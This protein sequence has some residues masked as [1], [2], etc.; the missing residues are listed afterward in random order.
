MGLLSFFKKKSVNTNIFSTLLGLIA[1]K[2]NV[3]DY[4]NA[5]V[6][7]VYACIN[8]KATDISSIELWME[9]KKGDKWEKLSRHDAIDLLNDVNDYYTSS[10]LMFGT[11]AWLE[12]DGNSYWYVVRNGRGI[13]V[14][15]WPLESS[16][17]SIVRGGTKLIKGYVYHLDNG[18]DVPFDT[19]Q[20]LHLRRFNPKDRAKGMGTI[21]AAAVAIDTD[22]FAADYNKNFFYNSAMPSSAV[23]TD[24]ELTDEQYARVKRQWEAAHRGVAN[25]HKTAILEGGLKWKSITASQKDMDYLEGRK[26]NRDEI[27][28]IFR[29]PK[30][31]IGIVED[32]NRANAE[33]SEYVFAK[34]VIKPDMQ[35]I[36][37]GLNEFYLPMFRLDQGRFRINF[38]DP[39]PQNEDMEIKKKES[40]ISK[41][42]YTIN[43]VRAMEG[44]EPIAGGDES[45]IAAGSIP[46]SMAAEGAGAAEVTPPAKT[47]SKGAI[48][49]KDK[50]FVS[51]RSKFIKSEIAKRRKEFKKLFT[52]IKEDMLKKL[53]GKK[54]VQKLEQGE[55]VRL[56]FQDWETWIGLLLN[57]S[58]DTLKTS[59]E[60]GG[61]EA[62]QRLDIATPFDLD[63][64]RAQDWLEENGLKNAT[65]IADTLKDEI[66]LRIKQGLEE[67]NGA[68]GVADGIAEFFDK[69]SS[70]RALRVA[71]SE[72]IAGYSQGSLEGYRQSDVV[73]AKEWLTVGDQDDECG[74]NEAQGAIPL[75]KEF[76]SGHDAPPA[77][78]N[79]RCVPLP[80]VK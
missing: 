13:P 25:A 65:Q 42:Y 79:C 59:L 40:G 73:E 50:L 34:R 57:A 69:Q 74:D 2:L 41:G 19:E 21:E 49:A 53:K 60:K 5:Y 31:I 28:A 35:F 18:K 46:L 7:W 78:P 63:N 24:Q 17:I 29:T 27:L 9:E 20:I 55:L 62:L 45:Y 36:A 67:G 76:A 48:K 56:L 23:E 15:I 6:G 51:L 4:V 3:K 16:K 33:A 1:P 26:F 52:D 75:D 71:R 22:R 47:V 77:H 14:E 61:R 68:Q 54:A 38:K 12:I 72:V 64:P 58:D 66:T 32:V 39:V 80:V 8:A 37:D 30:S 11:E 43:E 70:W 10:L 44:K